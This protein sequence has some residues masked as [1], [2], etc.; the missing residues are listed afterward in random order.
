[1]ARPSKFQYCEDEIIVRIKNGVYNTEQA[2][3]SELQ[4]SQEFNLSRSTIRK[5][6]NHLKSRGI[7]RSEKGRGYFICPDVIPRFTAEK[8]IGLL[9]SI[10]FN[11]WSLEQTSCLLYSLLEEKLLPRK[12]QLIHLD[13]LQYD[14]LGDLCRGIESFSGDHLLISGL[15]SMFKEHSMFHELIAESNKH[16]ILFEDQR[17]DYF[18]V[19]DTVY[20]DWTSAVDD[21][22]DTL[23]KKKLNNI[24]FAGYDGLHWS[25]NRKAAFLMA[26]RRQGLWDFGQDTPAVSSSPL[27]IPLGVMAP[28]DS[29]GYIQE[30]VD[31]FIDYYRQN[32][33]LEAVICANDKF[34]QLLSEKI[35]LNELPLLISFDNTFWARQHQISS[36]GHDIGAASDAIIKLLTHDA[37][38]HRTQIPVPA[39]F[40]DR[41]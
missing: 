13:P 8:K 5:A 30:A 6:L 3:P 10:T 32:S 1:M 28:L 29:E 24:I 35:P 40:F 9:M 4:M 20:T 34:I 17:P 7:I 33:D 39:L 18:P 11:D 41:T 12:N 15:F 21:V 27:E 22:V 2:L 23:I 38:Q 19:V 31:A 26:M 25:D 14:T 16:I 37:S 36:V